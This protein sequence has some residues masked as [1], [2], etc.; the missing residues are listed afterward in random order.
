MDVSLT[1]SKS[2]AEAS[3]K[4][5]QAGFKVDYVEDIQNRR[6]AA[7]SLGE[8]RLIDNVEI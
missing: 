5:S 6:L 2:A 3:A 8:V 7:A 4:L 1:E